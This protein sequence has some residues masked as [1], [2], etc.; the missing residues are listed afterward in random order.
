ME[1]SE[2][3]ENDCEAY[4][5]DLIVIGEDKLDSDDVYTKDL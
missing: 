3:E 1:Y 2:G 4:N 5:E